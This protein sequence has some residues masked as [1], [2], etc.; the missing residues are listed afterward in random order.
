MSTALVTGAT[1]FIGGHVAADL[2]AHGWTVRALVRPASMG[3]GRLPAGC[4]AV[5]GD[6]RDARSV[7]EAAAGVDAVFHVGAHYSLAR[8]PGGRGDGARTSRAP[9]NVL[10][11]AAEAGAPVVP[12][13]VGGH[14][15]PA[16][17]RARPA[18]RTRRCRR[19]R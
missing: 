2:M 15:R 16:G 4:E 7:H 14:G 18:T 19:R 11:A 12:L 10:A 17:R 6:L 5:A 13:L 8:A 3:S 9:R 1:G